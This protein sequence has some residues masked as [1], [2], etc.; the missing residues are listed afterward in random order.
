MDSAPSSAVGVGREE[1]NRKSETTPYLPPRATTSPSSAKE[2][3]GEAVRVDSCN[4][5]CMMDDRADSEDNSTTEAVPFVCE[6]TALLPSAVSSSPPAARG[7]STN[8]LTG[9]ENL[10]VFSTVDEATDHSLTEPSS[11]EERICRPRPRGRREVIDLVW[12]VRVRGLVPSC[13]R[14]LEGQLSPSLKGK[15]DGPERTIYESTCPCFPS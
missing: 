1:G 13:E 14:R 7:S 15:R 6:T 12:E 8:P 10:Q 5:G 3:T 9:W 11:E 2:S 4:K